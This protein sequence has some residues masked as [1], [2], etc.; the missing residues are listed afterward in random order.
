[1]IKRSVTIKGHRTSISMEPPFWSCLQQIAEERG[2][3]VSALIAEIDAT[4]TAALSSGQD[5]GGL[6]GTI[7]VFILDWALSRGPS[8]SSSE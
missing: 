7:R 1:M 3:S 2:L 8:P 4:R 6:S 5:Q